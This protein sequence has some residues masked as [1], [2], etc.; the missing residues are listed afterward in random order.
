MFTTRTSAQGLT[1]RI[2]HEDTP[3]SAK[4]PEVKKDY[5]SDSHSTPGNTRS[6]RFKDVICSRGSPVDRGSDFRVG[7]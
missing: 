1:V 3:T 6:V 7:I 5:V 2:G 4:V